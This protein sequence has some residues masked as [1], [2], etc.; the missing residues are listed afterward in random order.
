[1]PIYEYECRVCKEKFEVLRYVNTT[2]DDNV[3][4]PR[5]QADK[6]IKVVSLF[7]SGS[8]NKTTRAGCGSTG[9]T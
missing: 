7:S 4:C 8:S 3:R 9:S 2:D 1:M 6:P 5:C